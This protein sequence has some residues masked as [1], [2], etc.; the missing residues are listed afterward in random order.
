[1]Q[2]PVQGWELDWVFPVGLGGRFQLGIHTLY[3]GK[4]E[5][6]WSHFLLR[7]VTRRRVQ[8]KPDHQTRPR[9]ESQANIP[10]NTLRGK[11]KKGI[12][13]GKNIL[14]VK[15]TEFPSSSFGKGRICGF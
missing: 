6:L 5:L 13:F 12:Y 7:G 10:L 11:D 3:L 14:N 1:M 4:A 15:V 8:E 2:C 9:W